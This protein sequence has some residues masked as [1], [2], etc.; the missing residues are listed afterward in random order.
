MTGNRLAR[1]RRALRSSRGEAPLKAVVL[2][3]ALFMLLS[4]FMEYGRS[5]VITNGARDSLDRAVIAVAADNVYN[6]YTGF[7]EGFSAAMEYTGS[8]W[9]ENVDASDVRQHLVREL[10]VTNT[11]E[12]LSKYRDDGTLEYTIGNLDV[13]IDNIGSTGLGETETITFTTKAV[14]RV[15]MRMLGVRFTTNTE[16]TVVTRWRPKF[17]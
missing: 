11:A 6:S 2:L 14:V 16:V 15:P 9:V 7:R 8:S 12:G 3:M 17:G 4:V 1:L 10:G 5:L 13:R